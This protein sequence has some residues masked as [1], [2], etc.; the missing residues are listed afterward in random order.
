MANTPL[1]IALTDWTFLD[2]DFETKFMEAAGINLVARQCKTEAEL[3]ALVADADAVMTQFVKITAPVIAAMRQA[4]CIVRYGIGVDSI[5][6]DAARARQIPVCNV[7]DYCIDE[8]ADHTLAFMLACTRQVLP[9]TLY[10]RSGQWGLPVPLTALQSLRHCTVG[11]VGYGRIGRAVVQRLLAF[12]CRVLVHDPVVP[13]GVVEQS[14]AKRAD[15]NAL[16]AESDIVTLHCPSTSQTRRM[17]NA[18]T[19]GRM[20]AGAI[21]IN[22]GR[23]DLVDSAALMTALESGRLSAAALDVFDPEPIPADHPIH[24]R[25]NVLLSPHIASASPTSVHQL[26]ESVAR[27]AV[28]GATGQTVPNVVNGVKAR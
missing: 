27:T 25:S 22:V 11:V 3:I 6:L 9:N 26:R 20:K 1:K 23:G 2:L 4:R 12:N 10:L 8:V 14:G 17:L 16:L 7:P 21:F 24:Q 18:D 5:D 19:F 15:L 28:L 13:A